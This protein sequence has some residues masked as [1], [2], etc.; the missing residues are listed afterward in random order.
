LR[1]VARHP[2][3]FVVRPATADQHDRAG[4]LIERGQSR[5]SVN[6]RRTAYV[7]GDVIAA[8]LELFE[9]RDGAFLEGALL[10]GVNPPQLAELIGWVD[11]EGDN[12]WTEEE[13][14]VVEDF[15]LHHAHGVHLVT[16]PARGERP[17]PNYDALDEDRV[18]AVVE[19][20]G[21][22]PAAVLAYERANRNRRV[23]VRKLEAAA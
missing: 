17:W 3:S 18:L 10:D 6:L 9:H 21:Y 4:A 2:Q 20:A 19:D 12:G 1:F 7:P 16:P 23:L 13:R 22:D 11:T 8:A 14:H 15:L 5:V